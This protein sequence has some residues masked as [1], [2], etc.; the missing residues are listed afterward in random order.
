M[1]ETRIFR[2]ELLLNDEEVL[3]TV[4]RKVLELMPWLDLCDGKTVEFDDFGSRDGLSEVIARDGTHY[5]IDRD[6][7]EPLPQEA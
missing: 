3:A 2:K 1:K 4:P 7:T 5:R 6:W